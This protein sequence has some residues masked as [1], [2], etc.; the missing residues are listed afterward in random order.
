MAYIATVDKREEKEDM[1]IVRKLKTV[2]RKIK[3]KAY[4]FLLPSLLFKYNYHH[5]GVPL[6]A[7]VDMTP[8]AAC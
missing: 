3:R 8:D 1:Y 4:V 6:T 5:P 2:Q 7:R